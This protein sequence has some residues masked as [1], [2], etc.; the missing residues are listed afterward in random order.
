MLARSVRATGEFLAVCINGL[1]AVILPPRRP[2]TENEVAAIWRGEARGRRVHVPSNFGIGQSAA[3]VIIRRDSQRGVVAD[4][5]RAFACGRFDFIFGAAEFLHANRMIPLAALSW[6]AV[7][8]FQ[9]S[10]RMSW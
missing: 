10:R 2:F 5:M 4:E 6:R 7:F 3:C 1:I 8:G 9:L